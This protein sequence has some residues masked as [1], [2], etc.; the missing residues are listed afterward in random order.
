MTLCQKLD[1][2]DE[3]NKFIVPNY[4]RSSLGAQVVKNLPTIWET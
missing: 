4:Q 3:V 2:V 1:N